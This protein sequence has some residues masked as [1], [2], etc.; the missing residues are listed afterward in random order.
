MWVAQ[1]CQEILITERCSVLLSVPR[2]LSTPC[3]HVTC[4]VVTVPQV[5]LTL[6]VILMTSSGCFEV[7]WSGCAVT[8][9]FVPLRRLFRYEWIDV[10]LF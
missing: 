4:G 5:L 6:T 3:S 8:L 9:W 2:L 10:T 7:I 1:F